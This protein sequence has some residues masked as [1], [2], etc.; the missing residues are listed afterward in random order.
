MA[1]KFKNWKYNSTMTYAIC[2]YYIFLYLVSCK[3][4]LNIH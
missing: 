2:I 1:D 4:Y 3:G